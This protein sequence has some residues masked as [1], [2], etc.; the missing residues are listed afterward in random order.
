MNTL[1]V[2][3]RSISRAAF[4][5]APIIVGLLLVACLAW[6]QTTTGGLSGTVTDPA[7]AVIVGAKVQV[8]NQNT[9]ATTPLV[10]NDAG[11]YRAAFLIPGTYTVRV[12]A[13]GFAAFETKDILVQTAQEAVVN[14]TLTVG[15]VGQTVEVEG[16]APVLNTGN[17]Q[18]SLNVQ[19]ETLLSMPAI[20]GGMD[21]MAFT[22]PGI[23][24]GIGNVNSNGEILSANGQRGRANNFLLDGQDNN[25]P[26]LEGPGFLFANLEAIGEYEVITN[27]YSAEFGRDA[28]AI[29]NIRV[30]SGTNK[31][32][33][34][35]TYFRR[36]DSNW[37]A[38]DN[39]QKADGLTKPPAYKDSIL[40]GQFEG[41]I[42]KNK[43][44]FNLWLQRE[45]IRQAATL[46]GTPS[47]E[48]PTP[49]GLQELSSYFPNSIPLQDYIKYG[50]WS[51]TIGNPTII[52]S[53]QTTQTF[54]TP[55]GQSISVPFAPIE[56]T[57]AEPQDNWD[58]GLHVDYV[59]SDKMQLMGKFYD[60]QHAAPFGCSNSGYCYG[61]PS[62][63]KQA[64]GSWVWTMSPTW[65]N[66]FRFSNVRSE[67]DDFG[68][69]TFGF[70][71]FGSNVAS[72]SITGIQGFGLAY[73]LPQY[74]LIDSYQ[75]QDNVSKQ[76]G[77]H[78]LKFGFQ[79]ID[80]N[81]PIGFLPNG[82]GV[83]TFSNFQ[84]FLNNSPATY[85]GAAGITTEKPHELDQA[86]YFQDDYKILPHLTLNLGIRYEYSGQP[87]NLLNQETVARESNP[88][89]AIWNTSLPLADRVYP[90]YPAPDK[91]FAPRLG[92]AWSPQAK[93]GW[94]AKLLGQDA[95]VI[96]AG[97]S[98]G[99]DPAFYNLFLNGATAAPVVFAY[100][101]NYAQ[102][103]YPLMPANLTGTYL[104]S[105][106]TPPAGVDPRTLSQTLFSSNWESPYAVSDTIGIQRRFGNKSGLEIRYVGTEGVHQ[107]ATRN[108]NPL[109]EPYVASG[110]A[111]VLPAGVTPGVNTTC[112]GCN[113]RE[114]PNY[115]TIRLRDNSGH[116]TYNGL[117]TSYTIRNVA[118]QLTGSF[119]FTWSKTM[120][121]TSEVYGNISAQD[122]F[123]VNAGERALSAINTPEALSINLN[124][125]VPW[126]KG[127]TNWYNRVA[128]GWSLSMFEIYQTGRPYN[129]VQS[130]TSANP[131]EDAASD[132]LIG[133]ADAL[134]PFLANPQ[135]PLGTV[136]EFLSNGSLVNLAN[137][138]QPVTISQVHWIYNT[139]AADKYFG[140]P[141]GIP[142]NI[143]QAP[144][145]QQLNL[146]IYKNFAITERSK[147]QI[148]AEATN[149]F[150]H[151]SYQAPNAT[152]DSGTATTFMNSTYVENTVGGNY[153]PRIIKLG[154]RIIF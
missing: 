138:S 34:I 35:G 46:L 95:T 150:N 79:E 29:V 140:T 47:S 89:T 50:P 70:S 111:D 51:Q 18:L 54:T 24:I 43:L 114:N 45:W 22:S 20:Q 8:V 5:A 153:T 106:Y 23:T 74:R 120:D 75:Y 63:S 49:A 123:N 146:S 126:L 137:T 99:Y 98:I 64:G 67:Y 25:D 55:S 84:S 128:G 76:M 91:N 78:S 48:T 44:F 147:I 133:S 3:R 88:S 97:Y 112:S 132:S 117:Q 53:E 42:I 131:L 61:T 38:L 101:L 10:T 141:F 127:T 135:A 85:A 109:I 118:N 130:N 136:G 102:G 142:R 60:Q 27:Q 7:S 149:A 100:S 104:N 15:Q 6:G 30:R 66:E 122:P 143:L 134:R 19:P 56:R 93:G 11:L 41:P 115:S 62:H 33:G 151:V 144:P 139:L 94:L 14:A 39:I 72:V 116:S 12:Q 32:H 125:N 148:R 87:I 103:A 57:I 17:A 145:W 21:K 1:W 124:W 96:R 80:D 26:T 36:D 154:A 121:N 105:V 77:K 65:V 31:F 69:N 71:D 28:G 152:V 82:N 37:T 107:F 110:F 9:G 129:P 86:Y 90:A 40:A 13:P 83:Y 58:S 16:K 59:L 81:T 68:G 92:L 108:G 52:G 119:A 2:C 73:N 113:G 4:A